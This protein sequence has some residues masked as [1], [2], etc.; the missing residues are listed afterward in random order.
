MLESHHNSGRWARAECEPCAVILSDV[1]KRGRERPWH[2]TKA[3]S[4]AAAW[5]Y[6]ELGGDYLPYADRIELCATS[7]KFD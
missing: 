2:M 5:A 1:T 3:M 7:L 6:H 4:E